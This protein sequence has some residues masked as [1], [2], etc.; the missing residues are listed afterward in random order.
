MPAAGPPRHAA[1]VITNW[2]LDHPWATTAGLVALLVLGPLLAAW[3][4]GRPR[5]AGWL[6]LASLVPV[7]ALTLSP[8]G[9][10]AGAVQC[11]VQWSLPSWGAVELLANVAL[12]VPPALLATAATRRPWA[13]LLAGSALSLGIEAVQAV[14][15]G[16]GRACD[17]TDWTSN[18]LG[19]AAGVLLGV[20]GLA[21]HRAAVSRGGRA[22]RP[23]RAGR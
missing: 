8:T 4:A 17:T 16:L 12:F 11:T 1:G 3:A 14:T 5:V 15:T 19:A 23:E 18:T 20:L 7:A 21:L 2:L 22:P 10:G 6:A 13:V 9:R